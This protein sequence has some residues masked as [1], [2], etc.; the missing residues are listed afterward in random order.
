MSMSV[1]LTCDVR[2]PWQ[3]CRLHSQVY[4]AK[5]KCRIW[6]RDN[7]SLVTTRIWLCATV[8]IEQINK[9]S[10][11][12]HLIFQHKSY[13]RA[14][15]SLYILTLISR[16]SWL[17]STAVHIPPHPLCPQ[18][19]LHYLQLQ[20]PLLLLHCPHYLSPVSCQSSHPHPHLNHG[21]CLQLMA[22]I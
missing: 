14:F 13:E 2:R 6:N 22:G 9:V 18:T 15:N 1:L 11:H 4:I 12:A 19:H 17:R 3:M 8:R 16:W 20:A 10:S 5:Y 21:L 7:H